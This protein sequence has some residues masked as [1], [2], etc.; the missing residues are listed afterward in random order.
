M[1]RTLLLFATLLLSI[2]FHSAAQPSSF[3]CNNWLYLPA[4]PYSSIQLGDLDVPGTQITVEAEFCRTTSYTGGPLYAGDLVSKHNGPSNVNYL[5][6]PND[7]EIT[8]SNGYFQTPPVCDIALNV[9]YHVAMTY[10]GDTLR[11]YRNGILVSQ[12][13]ATGDLVQQDIPTE[14]GF[15]ASQA[16]P[17]N[18][19]GYINEVRI[20]NIVR[21]QAQ[22]QAYMNTPLPSPTNQTGLLAYYNFGSLVNLQGNPAWN[23]SNVGAPQIGQTDPYCSATIQTS[24][25]F[26]LTSPVTQETTCGGGIVVPLYG[27]FSGGYTSPIY[28]WQMSPDSGKTW[29]ALP[30][31]N[32]LAYPVTTPQSNQTMVYYYRVAVADGTNNTSPGCQVFSPPLILTVMPWFIADFT[33]TQDICNPLQVVFAGPPNTGNNFVWTIDGVPYTAQNPGDATLQYTFPAF[34]DYV[35]ALTTTG[36]CVGDISKTI[37]IRVQPADIILTP[38]TVSCAGKPVQLRTQ[39]ALDFCWSPIS[40]LD[41]PLSPDPMANPPATTK[42][43]FTAKTTG[44]NLVANGDFSGGNTGF[45]SGYVYADPNT[46]EGQY[47]VGT[48]PSNWNGATSGCGDHTT[49]SGNMLIVNGAPVAGVNVWTSQTMAVSPG[50]NY[51]FSVWVTSIYPVNAAILQFSINGTPLGS[52]ISPSTNTC[53]WSQF[54]TTWNSGNSTSATISLVNNNTIREGNDFALDDISFA[55]VILQT[56]SVTINVET[57]AVTATPSD[58]IV[59]IGMPVPLVA[60]GTAGYSWSPA[61]GL[62]DPTI[63]NPVARIAGYG[64]TTTYIVTGASAHGCTATAAA[65]ITSFPKSMTIGPD[66]LICKGDAARLCASGG[67]GYSWSP[68]AGL[69]NAS[70]P[71]PLARPDTTTLYT[72]TLTDIDQCTE[73]DSVTVWVK[74]VPVFQAPPDELVCAGSGV[75]LRSNNPGGYIYAWSPSAGLDN[76]SAPMPVATPSM[77]M[78]YSLQISDS[79]CAAYD[80]SFTLKVTV[81]DPNAFV[82]PNAFT[83]NG[84]GHNDC[85]GVARWGAAQLDEME[86]FNRWGLRVF[87]TRNPSDCWDG[88]Y[89]GQPQPTGAYVYIIRANTTCG[90]ITRTGTV[91]LIR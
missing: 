45:T 24:A 87:S 21:T 27:Y 67:N 43:Y 88:T 75:T 49:G 79:L 51:A 19:V 62:S 17:E 33:Y 71:D 69:D 3:P 28:S 85:F 47:T 46:T 36:T 10:D 54:Y 48:N 52:P 40:F 63:P 74:T 5:L 78:T 58:T 80:S 29:T 60:S 31:S 61:T 26:L 89:N 86:I 13:A 37:A 65:R 81:T 35:V 64:T 30:N 59:C 20:W 39:P 76:T 14:I 84:D 8:T 4:S 66:T 90:M 83:P 23:G 11:F 15:F 53:T 42:Y 7:A 73:S 44:V 72:V 77:D 12:I 25:S 70:S 1:T 34:G 32:A 50:T 91:M 82:V 41:D 22:I 9:T 38:D 56:D 2:P 16:L 57:A 6:R 18:F 55:P 68:P